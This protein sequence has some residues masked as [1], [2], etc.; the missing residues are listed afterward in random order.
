MIQKEHLNLRALTASI[1]LLDCNAAV[2]GK[3]ED[4]V[5]LLGQRQNLDRFMIVFFITIS[6]K[7][8]VSGKV[9][10]EL[11]SVQ[12]EE[13]FVSQRLA[14]QPRSNQS[15]KESSHNFMYDA[16]GE[17]L[18][19]EDLAV[20]LMDASPQ[21]AVANS[22]AIFRFSLAR[23]SAADDAE[24]SRSPRRE[25]AR[26]EIEG[27]VDVEQGVQPLLVLMANGH[28]HPMRLSDS[29]LDSPNF[30]RSLL[31]NLPDAGDLELT[32][33][34]RLKRSDGI[35]RAKG[36]MGLDCIRVDKNPRL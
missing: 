1:N 2:H 36:M 12:H 6:G 27:F 24:T 8:T 15:E 22:W 10:L 32:C 31:V 21:S 11:D 18:V 34:L 13:V 33:L 4:K 20:E 3:T 16:Q 17:T 29:H 25:A 23:P 30:A 5:L 19:L 28:A 7:V 35:S 26:V 14:P 9:L